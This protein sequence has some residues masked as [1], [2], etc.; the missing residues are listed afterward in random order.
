[1]RVED[2]LREGMRLY[3]TNYIIP[4]ELG[5]AYYVQAVRAMYEEKTVKIPA[6]MEKVKEYFCAAALNSK[7]RDSSTIE[8]ILGVA[9]MALRNRRV[10]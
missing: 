5:R 7:G 2:S 4:M 3:P 6:C 10:F 8:H 1:M 9:E